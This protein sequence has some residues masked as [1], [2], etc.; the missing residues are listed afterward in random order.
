MGFVVPCEVRGDYI[1]VHTT[2]R[3]PKHP[4]GPCLKRGTA[5]VCTQST[6]TKGGAQRS[7]IPTTSEIL[8]LSTA[9]DM[10]KTAFHK[11]KQITAGHIKIFSP[12]ITAVL[13]WTFLV[14]LVSEHH[15]VEDG[16]YCH[17]FKTTEIILFINRKMWVFSPDN[18]LST[19]G[20]SD[21]F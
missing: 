21:I 1:W 15:T 4:Q 9:H 17:C 16:S 20:L 11:L 13:S 18:T 10:P 2:T 7:V 8:H 5:K 19:C 12:I 6:G 14:S 3:H